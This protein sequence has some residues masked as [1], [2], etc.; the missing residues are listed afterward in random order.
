MGSDR[1]GSEVTLI[2][3]AGVFQAAAGTVASASVSNSG[4][5]VV[6]ASAFASGTTASAS[7]GAIGIGQFL[8]GTAMNATVINSGLIEVNVSVAVVLEY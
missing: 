4:D 5:L 6:L 7:A 2:V 8:A 3:A 1:R